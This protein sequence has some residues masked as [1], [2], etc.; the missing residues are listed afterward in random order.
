MSPE[1]FLRLLTEA[2]CNS[3][4]RDAL[5][6][7]FDLLGPLKNAARFSGHLGKNLVA[8]WQLQH[9]SNRWHD[10]IRAHRRELSSPS[11]AHERAVWARA[12]RAFYEP[13]KAAFRNFCHI[14]IDWTAADELLDTWIDNKAWPAFK[15]AESFLLSQKFAERHPILGANLSRS[16]NRNDA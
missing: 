2:C 1:R 7:V 6:V 10:Y 16:A 4:V 5:V 15:R 3:S 13:Q 8:A 14:A 11:F 9:A 12:H